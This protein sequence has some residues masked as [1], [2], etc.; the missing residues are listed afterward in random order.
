MKFIGQYIQQF[1][2]R[3]RNDVYLE[4]VSTGTIASGGNLGLDSN[5]KIVKNTVS[6]GGGTASDIT[7]AD[8]SS[9]TTCF[10]TFVT[11]ATGDLPLKTGSNL[12]FNSS[13]GLLEA[14]LLRGTNAI[15]SDEAFLQNSDSSS[16][17][18]ILTFEKSRS[19]GAL[20]NDDQLGR[21]QFDGYNDAGTPELVGFAEI[22]ARASDVTDGQEAGSLELLVA[23]FDGTKT[24]GLKLEGDT[25]ANGEVDV[26]IGAGA[27]STTTVAGTLTMGSTSTL[28]NSGVLQVAAQPSITTLTGVFTGSA[29]QLITDDGDG[30]VSSESGLIY[31]SSIYKLQLN[32]PVNGFPNLEL[33]TDDDGDNGG[34]IAFLL[35][36]QSLANSDKLGKIFWSGGT[37]ASSSMKSYGE[38][39]CF[40]SDVTSGSE[41]GR[42]DFSVTTG[43]GSGSSD[44]AQGLKIEGSNTAS[45]VNATIGNGTASTTTVSGTLTMGST[46]TLNN[47][48][49]LQVA[50]QTNITSLGTLTAL[51]VDDINLNSKTI[52]LTGSTG[53]TCAIACTTHGSTT[54]TTTDA[55]GAQAHLEVATDGDITMSPGTEVFKVNSDDI[56]LQSSTT[57]KPEVIISNGT[58]DATGASLIFQNKRGGAGVDGDKVGNIKFNAPNHDG[59]NN[60]FTYAHIEGNI[61]ESNAGGEAGGLSIMCATSDGG[62][63]ASQI[64]ISL[65]GASGGNFIDTT[66]GYGVRSTQTINGKLSATKRKFTTPGNTDGEHDADLVYIDAATAS[67]T[68]GKVYYLNSSGS[69]TIANA[70]AEA[71]ASGMLAV[72]TGS[73]PDANGMVVRGM[74]TAYDIAGTPVVGAPVYLRATDGVITTVK[75]T[76]SGNIVRCVGY[77]LDATNDQIWFNPDSTYIEV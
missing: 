47:S 69:W 13:N 73:D 50:A 57:N 40:V 38:I 9:D 45:V 16:V 28:N 31:D 52:T 59:S 75:P 10:P 74:V 4:D 30:T 35:E 34:Q 39:G 1:I 20:Q 46:A 42:M 67:T 76:T 70:D 15:Y 26:T 25:N 29:N 68:A 37:D 24:T 17:S 41:A 56:T 65:S 77:I 48:G 22:M 18:S 66:I 21:I 71:D 54:I 61:V 64:G 58:N 12:T 53:D 23:E 5:N 27:A 8:E 60:T 2:A 7:V 11:A 19:G 72:A 6:G 63:S 43:T 36:T 14:T 62:G 33:L 32:A 51:N 49:V 55:G 3:F 44:F